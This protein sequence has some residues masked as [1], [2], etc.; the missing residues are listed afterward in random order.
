M[1]S[2]VN[3]DAQ[4]PIFCPGL[5]TLRPLYELAGLEMHKLTTFT[6]PEAGKENI[7]HVV[8]IARRALEGNFVGPLIA[9][10]AFV[11]PGRDHCVPSP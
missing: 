3:S 8:A 9:V 10:T 6:P 11:S 7:E 1:S 4:T 2:L 5:H